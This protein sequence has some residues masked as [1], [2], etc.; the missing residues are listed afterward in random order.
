LFG[1]TLTQGERQAFAAAQRINPGASKATIEKAMTDMQTATRDAN[2]R[3]TKQLRS[4]G[5]DPAA[6]EIPGAPASDDDLVNK[7]LK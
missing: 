2:A 4:E 5:K 7:Y 3:L 6:Y 1:A